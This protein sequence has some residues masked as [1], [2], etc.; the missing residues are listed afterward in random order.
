VSIH[1]TAIIDSKAELGEDVSVGPYAILGANVRIGEGT[2]IGPH[3]VI[4]PGTTLGKNCRVFQGALIGGEPQIAGFDRSIPSST[5]IG[6]NTTLREY[7]TV[8]RSGQENETTRIGSDCMLMGYAHVAHDC[9]VGNNVTIV[10][11]TGLSGHIVVEDYAFI[12]GLVGLHQFVRIGTSAMIGGVT[13]VRQDVLPY[14]TVA[15]VPLELGGLNSVGLRRR[16][17][18]PEIRT[19]LKNAFKFIKSGSLNT[20]QAIEKI[21]S[22]IEMHAEIRYLIDFIRNSKRGFVR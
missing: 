20:T 17:V 15:G 3:A 16:D 7:V 18:K 4:E 1:P 14:S 12:S 10:N 6:D 19:A 2:E 22:E 5:E 8:H 13:A 11:Y 21:E 9:I